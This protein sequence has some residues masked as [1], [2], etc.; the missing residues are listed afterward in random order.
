MCQDL[1]T[2]R[3]V[4]LNQKEY[5]T[6]R[7]TPQGGC[8]SPLLWRIGT[9]DLAE[10][11]NKQKRARSTLFADDIA[12][13]AHGSSETEFQSSLDKAI[14]V[15]KEWCDRAGV[16]LNANK[17]EAMSTGR[18]R[19]ESIRIENAEIKMKAKLKYLGRILDTKLT[20]KDH[21]DHLKQKTESL[22]I[23]VN[24]L[25]WMNDKICLELK[26]QTYRSVLLPMIT[27]GYE[28]WHKV[29]KS[30]TTY[31]DKLKQM[32]NR[33][34]RTVTGAYR[35]TSRNKLLEITKSIEIEEE[36]EIL[37]QTTKLPKDERR[38]K[39]KELREERRTQRDR[40]FDFND[41]NFG[42]ITS[43]EA[44]WTLTGTGPFRSHLKRI[45]KAES[46]DCR[47][48]GHTDETGEHLITCCDQLNFRLDANSDVKALEKTTKLLFKELKRRSD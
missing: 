38:I 5:E 42:K 9:N 31:T 48:C 43:R 37:S 29:V 32:Q 17:T 15:V 8:A 13:V 41:L 21:L 34:L 14:R 11:L 7:G 27:F 28:A 18:V 6:Q 3:T 12:M 35:S 4:R 10:K 26:M 45:G 22:A 30:K 24:N 25:C 23:R 40:H 47:F 33:I 20:F 39:R 36:L 19:I 1:L 44:V 16:K 46:S 2:G